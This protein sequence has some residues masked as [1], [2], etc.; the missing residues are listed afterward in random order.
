LSGVVAI[1]YIIVSGGCQADIMM[2]RFDIIIIGAGHAGCEAALAAAR[3][4]CSVLIYNL[5]LDTVALMSCNPAVGGVAK[6]H[7]VKE[8]D[9]MG[10]EMGR[11]ADEACLH[12]KTLNLSKGPAVQAS[13]AQ[14]D[15]QTYRLAIR[16]VLED[17]P[18]IQLREGMVAELVAGGKRIVGIR[19]QAGLEVSAGAV[20]VTTGTFLNG[21]IHMGDDRLQAGRAGESASVELAGSLRSLGFEMGR[22]KTG[23]PPRLAR[24]SIDFRRLRPQEGD[25]HPRPFS[26]RTTD[27]NPPQIPCHMTQTT[28]KT[29]ELVRDNIGLSPLYAG[30]ITGVGARYCPS[31]EDKVMRF[32][33]RDSHPVTLELEGM[34]SPEIYAKGLGNS[35]PLEL[36]EELVR[37]VT[38]LE[39]ARIISP[40]YA[41]EYDYVQPTE[42]K[43]TLETKKI[44]GLFLAG[45]INGTSGYE[46]AA[47][48]GL[49]AGINAAC[50][51]QGRPPFIPDRSQAYMAVMV[52]DLVTKGTSEPYRM[53]TSRAEYRLLLREDNADLRLT[54][55]A[56]DLGLVSDL[57]KE[58]ISEKARQIAGGLERLKKVKLKPTARL[59][60]L[61]D[62]LGTSPIREKTGAAELVKR[63]P[64]TVASLM[65]EEPSLKGSMDDEVIRQIEIQLK[66]GGYIVRQEESVRRFKR[67]ENEKI[68]EDIDYGRIPG[69]SHEVREKLQRVR[70]ASLGQAAR[71]AGITPAAV[72]ILMVYLRGSRKKEGV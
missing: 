56:H 29:G 26:S 12:F 61:L 34:D 64:V 59:N 8:I 54:A 24:E 30:R 6:G 53:F 51:L 20:I 65:V 72:S 38:G 42:L 13:R 50:L 52:D 47:A 57:E 68:P 55:L 17:H 5:T 11:A 36:Q 39:S 58:R 40:A 63:P 66:Y 31:L 16:R 46:E 67:M 14:T 25:R 69:L 1:Y 18:L 10:G 70:P 62:S 45:Q 43:R 49:W 23:T 19:D 15:R 71:M 44:P 27:F 4:G 60:R 3:M 32:P 48:Q 22:L 2:D 37:T 28:R 7:L 35:F 9:A 33:D 41:I 21:L